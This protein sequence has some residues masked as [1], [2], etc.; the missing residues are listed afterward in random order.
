M[1][2]DLLLRTLVACAAPAPLMRVGRVCCQ[3]PA[4]DTCA[5]R[6]SDVGSRFDTALPAVVVVHGLLGSGSNFQSWASRL[7][8][9][10]AAK[11]KPRRVLLVDLRNH[12]D[13]DHAPTMS[14]EEMAADVLRLLDELGIRRAVLCGHSLGGK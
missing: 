5:L 7:S 11:G 12:G 6:H 13:S 9:D 14:F 4:A 8:E 2:P 3:L 10:C 1:R